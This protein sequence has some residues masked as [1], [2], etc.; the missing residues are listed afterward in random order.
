LTRAARSYWGKEYDKDAAK[1]GFDTLAASGLTFIDS[2]EVY[3]FGLSEEFTGEFVRSAPGTSFQIAS[4][5]A[6][7]PWR[8]T[9]GAV[10]DACRASLAR[11]GMPK[12][13]L[14][15]QH[16]P[17]F[18][19]N[20]WSNDAFIEGLADCVDAGLCDAVGVSNFKAERVRSAVKALGAR[21]VV[22]SSN[23]VQYSLLYREPERNGVLEACREAGVTVVAYSPLAQ[24]LLTGKYT[25]S[26]A[27]APSGP[28]AAVFTPARLAGVESLLGVMREIG[29]GRAVRVPPC[30]AALT[31]SHHTCRSPRALAGQDAGPDCHQLVLVQGHAAD[32][33][34]QERAAGPGGG[35]RARVAPHA[36]G[37]ACAGRGVRQGGHG[38]IRRTFR[39]VV[40]NIFRC[41]A[42]IPSWLALASGF[43]LHLLAQLTS[44]KH[45][46]TTPLP[47]A[48]ATLT[49]RP[50]LLRAARERARA[51][52]APQRSRRL[53]ALRCAAACAAAARA[54]ARARAAGGTAAGDLRRGAADQSRGG[55]QSGADVV[56]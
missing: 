35:G 46:T 22:L 48:P 2:A 29:Q 12:M 52:A 24:G 11:L 49:A 3:G 23:Q 38:G 27:A 1:A 25:G 33:G 7:L 4:K 36:R 9:R 8:F 6:P 56:A 17:G 28:R 43:A 55:Q 40:K 5:F 10:V 31:R 20:G 45:D 51:D 16:W 19:T 30:C 53:D 44:P 37:G 50:P 39:E 42:T 41:G 54:A 18:A 32:P 15:I 34:R 26:G 21:G 47:H 13:S 14:Y